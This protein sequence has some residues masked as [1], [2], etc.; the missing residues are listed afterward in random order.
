MAFNG[1]AARPFRN[2]LAMITLALRSCLRPRIGRSR[3]F[4]LP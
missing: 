1:M 3:A 4:S 2:G